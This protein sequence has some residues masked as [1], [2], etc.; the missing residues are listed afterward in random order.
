MLITL[1]QIK[2]HLNIDDDFTADD[3]YLMSLYAVA[4]DLVQKHI[5]ITFDELTAK[6]GEVPMPLLHAVLL[7]IGN[8]YANRESVSYANVS[9]VPMSAK[10]ILTM[11][12]DYSNHT[13]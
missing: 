5:D 11:Y 8:F 1:E 6:H 4:A 10:Y 12:R 2:K 9:E 13:F 7:I 3:E